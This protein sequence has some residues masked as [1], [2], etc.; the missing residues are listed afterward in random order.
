M[1]DALH[2][3][4]VAPS[5]VAV[6]GEASRSDGDLLADV[7]GGDRAALG[8]LA[9]R[10][11][12]LV[13]GVAVRQTGD[14][15]A[16]EDVAQAVWLVLAARAGSVRG[17]A[18]P[19]WLHRTARYAS[20][21]ANRAARRRRRRERA[22]A[23]D[24]PEVVPSP[25]PAEA[26]PLLVVLDDAI[27]SLDRRDRTAVV[28]RYLRGRGVADVAAAL[29]SSPEAAQKRLERAVDKLRGY[30]A[31]HGRG[32]PVT[33]AVVAGVLVGVAPSR[34]PAAAVWNTAATASPAVTAIAK[35]V[36]NMFT[37]TKLTTVAAVAVVT[38]GVGTFAAVRAGR[39]V[40]G[41]PAGVG[42]PTAAAPVTIVALPATTR[43]LAGIPGAAN[44]LRNPG[45]AG[46]DQLLGWGKG[47]GVEGFRY[48]WEPTAGPGGTGSVR[49]TRSTD[50]YFPTAG[51]YQEFARTGTKPALQ[52][53]VQVKADRVSKAVVD[54]A[55]FT[56]D[57]KP[58]SHQWAASI[59]AQR[60]G[61]PPASHDW[62]TYA[63]RVDVPQAARR[64]QVGLELYG[65]GDVRFAD[66]R[67]A[68]A[69]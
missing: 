65:P 10:Y 51:W 33:P 2:A 45:F 22:A 19:A 67:A 42:P 32:G 36:R 5:G 24:R 9:G 11:V 63:G 50:R 47:G 59:G 53:S 55:F 57:D 52:V 1:P 40:G 20:A 60:E 58:L 27:A 41:S 43:P 38:A 14:P 56:V 31:R 4:A 39:P 7:A 66:A 68:Y 23:A 12:D 17:P 34:A 48:A 61:D 6:S 16:A 28:E 30:F 54:V 49:L 18:L 15:H 62:R 26:D 37:I 29:G 35:G 8:T 69:D 46:T 25:A 13:Y 64:I 21:N 44:L 3:T